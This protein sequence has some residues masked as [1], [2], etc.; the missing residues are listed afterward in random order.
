M[1]MKLTS[2]IFRTTL[3]LSFASPAMSGTNYG[4]AG[5]IFSNKTEFE[6]FDQMS[7]GDRVMLVNKKAWPEC[8]IDAKL[9]DVHECKAH[10]DSQL[11]SMQLEVPIQS[12]IIW[13]R[14]K[15]SPTSNAIV[16]PIDGEEMP[17]FNT[18]HVY[19]ILL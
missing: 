8:A 16:I 3:V 18:V 2:A 15:D 13:S 17:L 12:V 9:N 4:F 6:E 10:I 14:T 5:E 7:V 1:I 19:L 11:E